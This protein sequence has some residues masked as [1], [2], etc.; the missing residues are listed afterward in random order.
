MKEMAFTAKA[1]SAERAES[2]GI[3]NH[4]VP[5]EKLE[6]Y[7]YE[8][9]QVISENAPLSISVMKNSYACLLARIR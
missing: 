6:S 8:L 1:I 9:A 2:L 7:V 4:V 5:S 3:I